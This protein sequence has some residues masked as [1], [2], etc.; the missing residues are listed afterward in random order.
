MQRKSKLKFSDEELKNAV[1]HSVHSKIRENED[2]NIGLDA[3]HKVQ[4]VGE[5]SSNRL[6][7]LYQK[8]AIKKS[9]YY[10]KN[11]KEKAIE[12][13]INTVKKG[14]ETSGKVIATALKNP[15]VL[16]AIG[17]VALVVLISIAMLSS[18]SLVFQGVTNQIVS[19][20]YVSENED[21]IATNDKFT[22]MEAELQGKIDDIEEDY[23]NYDEYCYDL[24]EITHDD[25]ELAS[26][27][28]ALMQN[29]DENSA[30]SSLEKIIDTMYT[31]TLTP[32]VETRYTEDG[33]S[34]EYYI[35]NV[36]LENIGID[37]AAKLLLNNEQ[38]GMY[39]V[40]L[41]TQGNKSLV[42][43]GG[44]YDTSPSTDIS[45][46]IFVDGERVGNSKIVDIALSQEGNVGGEPYWSWYGF[47]SRVEWCACFVSWVLNQSGYSEPKFAACQ[48]Q[49]VTYFAE[50][51][52]WI[53]G[54]STMI[55]AGD[56]I[57]FDW[58]SDG[59]ADH[60]GIVI[61]TDGS[62]V[63]VVEG[64]SWDECKIR[65]Y[66]LESTVIMG[67]GLMN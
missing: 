61:G 12:T 3:T 16:L 22:A 13:A 48:L 41:E 17:V 24:A 42:F 1:K 35:L 32:I 54:Y 63:Y 25:H 59:Y 66:D 56:V 33:K 31:L 28:T 5:F 10:S 67:Y 14:F 4:Q 44:S 27:L 55:A 62:R 11:E 53:S 9:Y 49:G 30:L 52:R 29:Y 45:G 39:E 26:Y 57:F 15:K 34:Y 8:Q 21:I 6:S 50:N 7:K 65:D 20:S 38:L 37:E 46:V 43:G 60:V 40:Y 23:P 36:K 64:N 2:D 18:L 51:G 19:T 58:E 47:D